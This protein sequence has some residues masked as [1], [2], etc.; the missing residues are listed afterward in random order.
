MDGR[1]GRID[2]DITPFATNSAL[3]ATRAARARSGVI[4]GIKADVTAGAT[5][6]VMGH[7]M[8]PEAASARGRWRVH[9][10]RVLSSRAMPEL[11]EVETVA[12]DL[13]RHLLP[14]GGRTRTGD[15]RRARRVGP[16]PP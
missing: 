5:A 1:R 15:L 3:T 16:D 12:R 14:E 4:A 10:E 13:R 7:A 2:A 8:V 11:P 9:L 6:D